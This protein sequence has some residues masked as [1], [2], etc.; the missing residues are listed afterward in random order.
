MISKGRKKGT[1]R[2]AVSPGPDVRKVTL[3]GDFT[4]W[5]PK[6]MRKQKDGTFVA[7]LSVA[8]GSYEYKYIIDGQ[9]AVD[10]DSEAW[11]ANPYGTVNSVATIE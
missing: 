10:P 1:I 9:W 11:A 5:Q 3:A 7:H 8:A 4:E 6:P 2:F